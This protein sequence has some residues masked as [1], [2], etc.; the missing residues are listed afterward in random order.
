MKSETKIGKYNIHCKILKKTISPLAVVCIPGSIVLRRNEILLFRNRKSS[1]P[2][3]T[4]NYDRPTPKKMGLDI[5]HIQLLED[6]ANDLISYL[7]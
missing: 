2:N 5:H 4:N 7:K 6:S 3:I 1:K